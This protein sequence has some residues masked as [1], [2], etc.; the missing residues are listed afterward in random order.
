MKWCNCTFVSSFRISRGASAERVESLSAHQLKTGEKKTVRLQLKADDLR[1]LDV[2][3]H[4]FVLKNRFELMV[5]TSSTDIRFRR[6]LDVL[7]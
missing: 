6:V 1:Y 4:R 7:P 2:I 5:G 3:N